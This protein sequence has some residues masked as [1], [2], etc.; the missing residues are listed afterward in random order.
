[1][2][3]FSKLEWL[4]TVDPVSIPFTTMRSFMSFL[5]KRLLCSGVLIIKKAE[6][7]I[8]LMPIN[9]TVCVVGGWG[10][11]WL[12]RII[13]NVEKHVYNERNRYLLG[14]DNR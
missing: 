2:H 8:C 11:G 9:V 5:N 7:M 4:V 1:M 12:S 13:K 3:K 14:Q 6:L 10:V